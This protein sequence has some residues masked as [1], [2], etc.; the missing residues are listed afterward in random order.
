MDK[1]NS[2]NPD[3]LE[4]FKKEK[5]TVDKL[6]KPYKALKRPVKYEIPGEKKQQLISI[7][8]EIIKVHIDA[9]REKF[10]NHF[11]RCKTPIISFDVEEIF[12]EIIC[13]MGI[14]IA[15]DLSYEIYMDAPT[16]R[17]GKKRTKT[18]MNHVMNWI[19]QT[20]GTPVILIHGFNK[21]ET[22]SIDIL[23]KKGKVINTQ[24]ELREIIK[25]GNEF[26]IEKENL[27]DF[28]DCVGFQTRACTFLKHARDF[29]E[30]PKKKLVFL[31]PHQAKICITHAS[32]GEPF[33]RCTLCEKPQDMFLYCL[34]DAFTTVL[35]HVL[36]ESW[37][38][39][40]MAEKAKSQA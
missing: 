22:A 5:R 19:K 31:W 27:H 37:E 40:V 16:G 39:Q 12:N 10:K 14:R 4:K 17:P 33:R 11:S 24:L 35:V 29:P 23:K 30:L 26:G 25:E 3:I 38:C 18:A 20:K 34:E 21:N 7:Y 15:P 13:V 36:H 28:Q 1:S 32:K 8:S 6:Y 2:G 9:Y